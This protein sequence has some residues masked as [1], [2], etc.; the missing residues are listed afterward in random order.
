MEHLCKETVRGAE[1]THQHDRHD[2]DGHVAVDDWRQAAGKAALEGTIQR[3]ATA[4]LFLDA[5]S[6]DDVGVHAHADGQD[7]AGD[8]GQRQGEALKHREITGDEGQ[9]SRHLT[10]QCDAGQETGQTVQ[11]RHQDHDEGK[12]D[13]TGQ[14]H[15]A[16]AVLAQAGADGGVAVHGQRKRQRA[17][18][19]LAGHLDDIVLREGVGCRACDDSSAV[20]NGRM[21]RGR[22]DILVIQPD[23][24]GA[25]ALVEPGGGIAKGFGTRIGELEGH[26]ILR[27]AAAHRAVLRRCA[28]DHGAVQDQLTVRTAP[29]P[30]GQVGGG[31]DLFDGSFGVE[32]R[33]AGLPRKFED[34]AVGIVVH[35]QLVVGHVQTDQTVLNDELR[36]V[37]LLIGGIVAVRGCK[38]HVDAALDIHAEADILRALDIGPG[39]IAIFD[40][41][42]EEC[43]VDK[44]RDQ[45]HCDNKLPCFAFRLHKNRE[46]SK[47]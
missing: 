4:Q 11:R 7:D 31:A 10:G 24:D 44:R 21:D 8:A 43:R 29:L 39:H 40:R 2:D 20:G 28:L 14:H 19:D 5:L 46:T 34:Q 32:I 47:I 23:A 42:A 36:C 38:R 1:G 27:R 9:R 35:I 41:N 3:L 37:Q 30:E 25:A 18:V 33:L 15:S 16:Q 45:K 22:A 13:E 6:G 26:I 17:G 12:S